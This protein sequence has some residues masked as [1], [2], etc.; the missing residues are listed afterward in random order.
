MET[1]VDGNLLSGLIEVGHYIPTGVQG[2]YGKGKAMHQ[3]TNTLENYIC[4]L[5]RTE[6]TEVMM[7]PPVIN[8]KYIEKTEYMKSFPHLLGTVNAF[9]GD[10]M[11]HKQMML[12]VSENKSWTNDFT[13]TDVVMTPAA[14]YPVYPQLTGILPKNGR[15]VEVE[16]Y[17]FRHE[18]SDEPTRMLS[19]KMLEFVFAGT[20]EQVK[21][22][23]ENWLNKAQEVLYK[24]ELEFEVVVANDPFFGKSGKLLKINQ[25]Q[26]DS[27]YEMVVPVNSKENPTAV[28]S[29][30]YHQDH[31]SA[32][33]KIL[34][35]DKVVAHTSCV[36]FGI[37]RLAVAMMKKHGYSISEWPESVKS[38]LNL[39]TGV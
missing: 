31:F 6:N 19:F 15:I 28:I 35:Q 11:A 24:L 23:R 30:N 38:I 13:S 25:K 17:C 3:L 27:K 29:S 20:P 5:G 4:E 2:V 9:Y 14:C 37:E 34:T 21:I 36:A 32:K 33:Y 8:K 1:I 16:S 12:N 7:F 22:W 39:N 26:S 18:P 10:E